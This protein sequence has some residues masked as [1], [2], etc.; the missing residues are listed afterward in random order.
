MESRDQRLLGSG[1]QGSE[2]AGQWNAGI[3][4]IQLRVNRRPDRSYMGTLPC[5]KAKV[6]VKQ[7]TVAL[8]F[9]VSYNYTIL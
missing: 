3:S 5:T 2:V 9:Q 7:N 1:M 6:R 8:L 4:R